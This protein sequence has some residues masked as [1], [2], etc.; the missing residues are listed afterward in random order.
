MNVG[1]LESWLKEE[2]L[3]FSAQTSLDTINF[4]KQKIKSLEKAIIKRVKLS[5]GYRQL[6][7][8]PGIGNILA[9]TI[10]LEVGDIKRFPK[11]GP[12]GFR[13]SL[14]GLDPDRCLLAD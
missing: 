11:V 10:M 1:A 3:I 13:Y 9:M 5:K 8:I 12:G 2:H 14:F 7:T 4:L 6:L